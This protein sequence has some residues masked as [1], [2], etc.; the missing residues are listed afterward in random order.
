MTQSNQ[1][2]LTQDNQNN[3]SCDEILD[4]ARL[5]RLGVDTQTAEAYAA[6]INKILA[7][8]NTLAS[9]DTKDL[10]PLANIH[11]AHQPLRADTANADIDRERNQSIAPAV[12]DGLYL[13][14]QVI[15]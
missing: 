9:V 5:A 11:E 7:M 8:M 14:P 13:V 3:V 4:V 12:E 15:E 10:T 2:D 6:D 1:A